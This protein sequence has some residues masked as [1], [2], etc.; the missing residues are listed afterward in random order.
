[1]EA[2]DGAAPVSR[3]RGS[4]LPAPSPRLLIIESVNVPKLLFHRAFCH[5]TGSRFCE[6][7]LVPD[8]EADFKHDLV[9]ADLSVDNVAAGF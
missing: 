2:Y 4:R 3:A 1:M 9:V 6:C 7:T 8:A 5:K